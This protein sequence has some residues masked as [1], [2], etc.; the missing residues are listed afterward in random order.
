MLRKYKDIL[1]ILI[2]ETQRSKKNI[3]DHSKLN[4]LDS[5]ENLPDLSME[6]HLNCNSSFIPFVGVFAP[7]DTFHVFLTFA[8]NLLDI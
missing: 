4:L 8:T 3:F 5:I 1:T 2:G 7:S 6:L